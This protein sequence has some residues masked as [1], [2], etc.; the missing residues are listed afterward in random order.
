MPCDILVTTPI[1]LLNL[2]QNFTINL[3]RLC[4]LIIEQIDVMLDKSSKEVYTFLNMVDNM[5][6]HRNCGYPVQLIFTSESWTI[7]IETLFKKLYSLPLICIG[8]PLEA[9]IYGKPDIQMHIISSD[10]KKIILGDILRPKEYYYKTLIICSNENEIREVERYL[11]AEG[12]SITILNQN[13]PIEK[14][15]EH[16]IIWKKSK[17]NL[18]T[19]IN[20]KN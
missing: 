14:V 8:Q 17:N 7:K 19:Y 4:H 2:L 11:I 13:M 20:C 12:K 6:E 16:E 5:L 10:K 18:R 3:K 1:S 9:A 15:K